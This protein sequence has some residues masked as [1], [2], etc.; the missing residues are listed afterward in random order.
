MSAISQSMHHSLQMLKE[1][2]LFVERTYEGGKDMG[3]IFRELKDVVVD[4]PSK[5]AGVTDEYGKVIWSENYKRASERTNKLAKPKAMAY[6]LVLEQCSPS[7]VSKLDGRS[8]Y[9]EI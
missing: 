7:V 8:G 4:L 2:A 9:A 5:P 3:Y 1:P 6:A